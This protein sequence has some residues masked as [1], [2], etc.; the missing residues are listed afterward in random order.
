M[1]YLVRDDF[2][3]EMDN[4]ARKTSPY[5]CYTGNPVPKS[6]NLLNRI[7][8]GRRE[9]DD[10]QQRLQ[11]ARFLGLIRGSGVVIALHPDGCSAI[12]ASGV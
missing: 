2:L 9:N 8:V 12:M 5:E 3:I 11:Q 10:N 4:H 6:T 1:N 7:L